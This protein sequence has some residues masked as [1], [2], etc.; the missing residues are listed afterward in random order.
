MPDTDQATVRLQG[1]YCDNYCPQSG[2]EPAASGNRGDRRP[3]GYRV[4]TAI[5]TAHSLASN[6]QPQATGVTGDRQVTGFILR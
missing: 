6:P 5:T 4:H 1:S 3:S 2:I